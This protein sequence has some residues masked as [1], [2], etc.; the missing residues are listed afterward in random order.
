MKK[1]VWHM[2]Y[3]FL[4]DQDKGTMKRDQSKMLSALKVHLLKLDLNMMSDSSM[5]ACVSLQDF[6]LDDCRTE[7]QG[8]ITK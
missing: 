5:Q 4:Y 2:I 1:V 6:T 7:K 8:G 3:S